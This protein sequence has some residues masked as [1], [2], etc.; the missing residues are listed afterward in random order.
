MTSRKKRTIKLLM[1]RGWSRNIAEW[2]SSIESEEITH[3]D[4]RF[5]CAYAV[6]DAGDEYDRS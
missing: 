6:Y 5:W 4:I 2:I 3:S 1:A